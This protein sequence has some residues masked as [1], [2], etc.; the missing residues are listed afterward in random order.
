MISVYVPLYNNAPWAESLEMLSGFEY[1]AMDNCSEDAGAKILAGKGAKV[2]RHDE[3]LGRIRNWA[4]C[5]E[6]FLD[7]G[8]E[9]MKWLFAGDRLDP[10]A[11]QRLNRAIRAF[12]R[13]CLIIGEYFIVEG[14]R[15]SRWSM[16]PETRLIEPEESMRLIAK[17]GNWFGAPVGQAFGHR[18]LLNGYGFGELPWVADMYFCFTLARSCPVL[19]LA[20]PVGEFHVSARKYYSQQAGALSSLLQESIVRYLAADALLEMNGDSLEHGR[21]V[22][23]I[24]QYFIRDVLEN[25]LDSG[26][27]LA[28]DKLSF[29]AL[30]QAMT[31]KLRSKMAGSQ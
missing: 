28:L 26:T 10:E 22:R 9:W 13:A 21:L 4:S 14:P 11:P 7:T 2:F 24:E 23:S 3:N 25:R 20:E 1:I 31:C 18:A 30:C 15:R 16:F 6:H 5:V 19:Y 27:D 8:G 17:H 29:K 12:P